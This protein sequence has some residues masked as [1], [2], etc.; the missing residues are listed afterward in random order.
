MGSRSFRGFGSGGGVEGT[1]SNLCVFP[2]HPIFQYEGGE[3]LSQCM[4]CHLIIWTKRS[5]GKKAGDIWVCG[6]FGQVRFTYQ[7]LGGVR[8]ASCSLLFAPGSR[9]DVLLDAEG[10]EQG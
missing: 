2:R 6:A 1:Y 8:M 7:Q 3:R 9:M 5:D 4:C 10:C